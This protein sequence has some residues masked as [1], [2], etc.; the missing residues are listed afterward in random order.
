MKKRLAAVVLCC[1]VL[2][3]ST[4]VFAAAAATAPNSIIVLPQWTNVSTISLSMS[5]SGGKVNWS[6][7]INGNSNVTKITAT[8][9]LEKQVAASNGT[10]YYSPVGTWSDSTTTSTALLTSNSATAT[11][12]TYKLSL[13][14]VV[15]NSSG[16][17]ETVSDALVR[18]F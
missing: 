2:A 17:S 5:Y 12:G 13:T 7:Y 9:K 10:T 3:S 4:Q 14:A 11:T 1:L 8:Y 6:G 16:V 15:T 18:T